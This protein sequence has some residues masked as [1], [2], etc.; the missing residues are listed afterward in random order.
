MSA[1]NQLI[2][3]KNELHT[4]KPFEVHMNYCVDNNFKSSG[5]SI[6]DRFATLEE[7]IKYANEYCSEEI[8]EYGT[9]VHPSCYANC[10][11]NEGGDKQ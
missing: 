11:L 2:I 3:E 10:T 7:A 6:L 9:Y 5:A 4:K 8:V 1:N